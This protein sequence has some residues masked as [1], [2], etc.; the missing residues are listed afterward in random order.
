[1]L[2]N[3]LFITGV[4]ILLS[5]CASS[6]RNSNQQSLTATVDTASVSMPA[7]SA[8][9]VPLTNL[10]RTEEGAF[11]LAPGLYESEFKTY[12]LQPG[13]PGPVPND[14]YLQAPMSGFRKDIVETILLNSRTR[15]DIPQRNV[16][17][18]LWSVVSKSDFNKLSP[19]V[20]SDAR[21]LL[22]SKQIFELKGG[23]MG[24][25]KTVSTV[26][27]NG[28]AK[29]TDDIRRLFEAGT[30]SYESFEQ[31][32]VLH[33]ASVSR[34]NDVNNN[35]WYKQKGN[36][37]VRHI[38]V[39]YQKI[40]IQVY[41]PANALDADGKSAGEYLVFDPVGLQT[42]PVNTNAQ[43]LGI[44]APVVD[45]IREVIKINRPSVPVKKMPENKKDPKIISKT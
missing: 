2:K 8:T 11:V 45:I 37:Y 22:T 44:G 18:L 42:I 9:A 12:C 27:P 38:P 7:D 4:I 25:V 43:R 33:Q 6:S 31:L 32:A 10:S 21:E 1:M 3:L 26:M 41:V 29:S 16:Q 13:T 14:A 28:I 23:V 34:H 30:S 17:L 19:A 36:Y 40:K 35:Q 39:S 15:T 5:A 24:V 20:R